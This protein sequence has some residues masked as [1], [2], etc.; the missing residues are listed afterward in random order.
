MGLFVRL[1]AARL[2][3]WR[4]GWMDFL[5][6]NFLKYG[7]GLSRRS[8]INLMAGLSY[9]C[10]FGFLL[11]YQGMGIKVEVTQQTILFRDLVIILLKSYLWCLLLDLFLLLF[12]IDDSWGLGTVFRCCRLMLC[13]HTSRMCR[14]SSL[15]FLRL[16]YGLRKL[17]WFYYEFLLII[18]A[19]N[20]HAFTRHPCNLAL[21]IF[22]GCREFF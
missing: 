19:I 6:L 17:W 20:A 21:S 3:F 9:L 16:K 1:K 7:R 8:L 4:L 2:I 14:R 12:L 13:F 10:R 5:Q 11:G 18:K 15:R 22:F